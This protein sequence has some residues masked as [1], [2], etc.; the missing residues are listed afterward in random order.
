MSD[1]AWTDLVIVSYQ[2]RK[3]LEAC[4]KSIVRHTNLPFHVIIV[5]N[6][7]TDG[8]KRLAMEYPHFTWIWNKK[9]IGYGKAC[10]QGAN[11]GRGRHI[12]FLNSDVEVTQGW[13]PPILERLES[14]E[15]IAMVGPRLVS[16]QGRLVGAGVVGDPEHPLIRGWMEPDEPSR[17]ATP[18][19][20]LSLCGACIAVK[21]RLIPY[22]GLFDP[23]F[24]HYFEET[25]LCYRMRRLGYRVVYEPKSKV[26]HH[27]S[28]SCKEQNVL[29]DHYLR[30]K[31]LF[32]AKWKLMWESET[33]I[34]H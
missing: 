13:L 22:T 8:T 30:S 9:N 6:G 2:T 19:D 27:V 16:P 4:L 25:D 20:C 33:A 10:N 26:I 24:F 21:R 11:A 14:D 15:R 31:R 28:A 18:T 7:S 12:L 32:E 1:S 34:P 29:K 17:Y 3:L 5:D 23:I